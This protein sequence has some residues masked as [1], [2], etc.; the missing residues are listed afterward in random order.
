M[1]AD[2]VRLMREYVQD[3]LVPRAQRNEVLLV[4]LRAIR[5]WGIESGQNVK[6][7]TGRSS[8]ISKDNRAAILR[9]LGL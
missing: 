4:V 1:I 3:D 5:L 7:Q 8:Y 6:I 2:S 9:R